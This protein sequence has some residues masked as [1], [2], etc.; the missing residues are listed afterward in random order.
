[1]PSLASMTVRCPKCR[2]KQ[3]EPYPKRCGCG[4]SLVAVLATR[5]RIL[6]KLAPEAANDWSD[7]ESALDVPTWTAVNQSEDASPLETG[8]NDW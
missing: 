4:E 2:K 6:G 7:R 1:M 8:D 3:E 5:R